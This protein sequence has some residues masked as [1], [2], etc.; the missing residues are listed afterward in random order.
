[1]GASTWDTSL[2]AL[3][4]GGTL[5]SFGAT[6]GH[7]VELDLRVLFFKQLSLLGSTMGS[8]GE[9]RAAWSMVEAGRIRPVIDRVLPMTRIGEAQALLEERRAVGKVILVQDL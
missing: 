6:A 7:R 4:W 1:V 5:V 9:M 8:M 2:R 3:R